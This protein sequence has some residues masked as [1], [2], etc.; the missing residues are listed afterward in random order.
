[1]KAA[2]PNERGPHALQCAALQVSRLAGRTEAP[3]LWRDLARPTDANLDQYQ[4]AGLVAQPG[5]P[6]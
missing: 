1:M 6:P 3:A 4:G 5:T 2:M